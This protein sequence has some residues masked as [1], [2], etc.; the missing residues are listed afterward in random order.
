MKLIKTINM[1]NRGIQVIKAT[2][3]FSWAEDQSIHLAFSQ[4]IEEITWV[5][6]LFCLL[7]LG[8][9]SSSNEVPA[10]KYS[11]INTALGQGCR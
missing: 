10:E 4:A 6:S 3:F 5:C 1:N 2:R 9:F 11:K 7:L 8:Y